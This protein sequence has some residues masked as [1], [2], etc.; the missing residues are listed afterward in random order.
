[1]DTTPAVNTG[2]LREPLYIDDARAG[3]QYRD[4][5]G[6]YV[7]A[8]TTDTDEQPGQWVNAD[9]AQLDRE[10]LVRWLRS[11]GDGESFAESVV[12]SLLGHPQGED[13]PYGIDHL[14]PPDGSGSEDLPVTTQEFDF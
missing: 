3:E 10:S 6:I 2:V 11:R 12:L 14:Q 7:R 5:T 13:D 9:I 4:L 8:K 1:M